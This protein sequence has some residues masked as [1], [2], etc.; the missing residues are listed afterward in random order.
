[1]YVSHFRFLI[2]K[3]MIVHLFISQVEAAWEVSVPGAVKRYVVRNRK[4]PTARQAAPN[5]AGLQAG[6]SE[7]TRRVL[8][9]RCT[10]MEKGVV[11]AAA[12]VLGA[13]A[14][15]PGG[16]G[17]LEKMLPARPDVFMH[18]GLNQ[19]PCSASGNTC[20]SNFTLMRDPAEL[21]EKF[22]WKRCAVIGNSGSLL[23]T[24]YGAA[25]DNHDVVVRM[26]IAPVAGKEIYVGRKTSV[27]MINSKWVRLYSQGSSMVGV[28]PKTTLIVRV[29][30]QTRW[31]S[32]LY[33]SMLR[34]RPDV[35]VLL[36]NTHN[37]KVSQRI[38]EAYRLCYLYNAR[39]F[40]GGTIPSSGFVLVLALSQ[41]CEQ[42]NVYGFGR[43][44]FQGKL[45]P[46][47]YYIERNTDGSINQGS[48]NHAFSMELLVL[49]ELA[50]SSGNRINFCGIEQANTPECKA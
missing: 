30:D 12:R 5:R 21:L 37:V 4:V 22:P 23:A 43:P 49:K 10:G 7:A 20:V 9:E 18:R 27:R 14:A 36:L 32:L 1:M 38:L 11:P 31:F 19:P 42:V 46:Y 45:V 24:R 17:K 15:A 35:S 41:M 28:G 33:R 3:L 39:R 47:Q 29:V 50:R 16:S 44:K 8:R 48:Q 25:I 6:V 13:F 40:E 26:N 34:R 2:F